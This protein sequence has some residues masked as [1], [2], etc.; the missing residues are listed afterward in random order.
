MDSHFSILDEDVPDIGIQ[1]LKPTPFK[2]LKNR[3]SKVISKNANKIADWILNKKIIKKC[4]PPK[5][6]E[7]IDLSKKTIYNYEGQFWKINLL[8]NPDKF[9]GL[10]RQKVEENRKKYGKEYDSKYLKMHYYNDIRSLEDIQQCLVTTYKNEDSA[11]KMHISFGYVTEK[12]EGEEYKIKLYQPSQQYFNDKPTL[13]RNKKDIMKFASKIN[14]EKIIY[15][16][17][18]QFPNSA[19]RLIG[20]YSMAVKITRLDYPIGSIFKLPDYITNSKQIIG[21]ERVENNLCFWACMALA[22]GCRSDKYIRKSKKLFLDFYKTKPP[23]DYKGFDYVNELDKYE[24][25]NEKYAIN[26]VKYY[27]DKSIEY[28]QRSE[29]NTNA[30]RTPIYLNLYLEH[31]SYIP[32]LEKLSKMYVCNRCGKRC[33]NNRDLENH[34]NICTLE[35]DDT[36]VKHPEVYEK[37]R[38]DVVELCDWFDIDCDYKYDYLI[39]FDF[40]SILQKIPETTDNEKEE[41]KLRFVT[42]HIPVSVSIATNVPG[43]D[44][45]G[46]FITS[47]NPKKIVSRM[48]KYFEGIQ[49]QAKKLMM[50]KFKPLRKKIKN[51]YNDYEKKYYLEKIQDYCSSIPI[52]GFNS[53]FY[54]INLMTNYGFI[55][56]ILERDKNPFVIKSGTRYRVIKTD[57]FT[58]LDQM[59]YCAAGTNLRKFIKAYDIGE[60][61]GYFPYEWFDSYDKL[62]CFI[63]DLNIQDF[64]S[65]LKNTKMSQIE[66][67]DLMQTCKSLNLI[68]IKDLLKWYNNL[69]VGPMLKAC[70]KQ[71]EFFYTFELDMYKDGF[72]LPA[73]SEII[74]FKFAQKDFTKYLKQEPEVDTSKYFL[75]QYINQKIKSYQSQDKKVK[76]SLENYISVDEI[77]EL[78]VKQKYVCHYCWSLGTI[79]DWS[80]DRIDCSKAHISGNCVIACVH[81]NKERKDTLMKKFFRKKA[82]IRYAKTHPMIHLIDKKNKRVYYKIKD[83]IVGGPSIVYHRYHEV[84]VTNI[85]RVH[86]NKDDKE[87]Y[88]NDDGKPVKKIVGYDA[89]ALYLNCLAQDQLCGKLEWIPTKEEYKVEYKEETKGMNRDDKNKYKFERELSKESKIIQESL[90]TLS[91]KYRDN[92]SKWLKY[93]DSFFGLLEI[94]IKIPKDKYEYFGEM[95]PIFKNIEYSEKKAGD[96]MKNIILGT[97]EKFI[98]S[99]KLIATLK[100]TRI[101]I[102]S[103]R[104]KWLIE[105]GAKIT[106]IY[107]VIPAIK[108]KP[109]K[110]FADWVSDERRKGDIDNKYAIIAEA[111]KTVGNSAYGR[112]GMN[113]NNFKNIKFCTEKQ[114]NRAKNNYFYYDA[115]EYN[116]V[117]EVTSRPRKVKQNMPIQVAF[118]VLDD[119]KQRMLEFYYDCVDK[120][121]DRSDFQYMYMDTDSAYMGITDDFEKLIK[122]ELKD[123]FELDKHNWFPRTDTKEN[124]DYDKRKPGLFKK[125]FEGEGMICLCSKTYYCWGDQDKH[126]SKGLQK[127][128]N[129]QHLTRETYKKCLN[130]EKVSS[131][132]N[133]GFRFIDKTMKTYEQKKIG[134]TSI[135][136][137]GIV[138]NDGVHVHPL[139]I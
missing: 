86:Y 80:L 7:L 82:L 22:E 70:L 93:L 107:G 51:H 102:K 94:D 8:S 108:E 63:S 121:I 10:L 87:W 12:Y 99:R 76:R 72:S 83:N 65:S 43:F 1:P 66:F 139:V 91:T 78:F 113:K 24:K 34:M 49:M 62:D 4:L 75:P 15:K 71:K 74:L 84:G 129:E 50:K 41:T 38:N 137:K 73:L 52:V 5:I 130:N 26:I 97:R 96:Y 20:V 101:L 47:K 11:F 110:E 64:D 16:I 45:N 67:D 120:Y 88:Y 28:V 57:Q 92:K 33:N 56:K 124:K 32:S 119:A 77:K 44:E 114:F 3:V 133:K 59:S 112:T 14:G 115:E 103:N 36:F 104:L 134:I 55:N 106:K 37:K 125:E 116:G 2:L 18:S 23:K 111:A 48:F 27:E 13:I 53:S 136:V 35:Q 98:K 29:F 54:D 68:Y 81:C 21:L 89:N 17:A 9:E 118:N 85:N 19:T 132:L 31:F 79:Y 42:N 30:D 100:A 60:E 131:C 117:Y 90:N 61:K 40:E 69:D 109:F 46:Y 58:F 95:P 127:A 6:Q 135:Y 39:T 138:M 128:R 126:S 122:P 25:F 123:E 105:K